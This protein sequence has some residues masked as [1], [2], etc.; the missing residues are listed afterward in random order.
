MTHKQSTSNLT[1][2]EQQHSHG[3]VDPALL[4]S[5]QGLWAVKWSLIGL[6]ITAFL[7]LIV[8]IF[9]GSISLLADTLH[10]FGDAFT[11]VPL[12]AAFK[13]SRWKPT[14]QFTYGYGRVEDLAGWVVVL[15]MFVSAVSALALAIERFLHPQAIDHLG[16]VVVASLVGFAGNE[17]VAL[18]RLKV[19]K[20]IGSA[21]LI[22]DGHHA[23][24]DGWT[25]LAVLFS[26]L[27]VWLG[28]P[29]ADPLIGIL[30]ALVIFRAT[31]HSGKDILWRS[32][33]G[34]DPTMVNEVNRVVIAVPGVQAATEIRARWLGHKMHA[35]INIAVDTA[36][37]VAQG[38]RIM[39]EVHH[40]LL[41][42]I[43][44]L[45]SATIHVDP[46]EYAGEKHHRSAE[47]E[48]H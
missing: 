27:G 37:S 14:S 24:T 4:T 32:L 11:A 35:E 16:W 38:H 3:S 6:A 5:S 10:N 9:S 2:H 13:A 23:R 45:S 15:A 39:Q 33:D 42:E 26:A 46:L 8:V 22:A 41:H 19:G 17:A 21:A 29:L 40:Q 31:W 34:I 20:E 1:N 44:H 48:G 28:Y 47:H 18:F 7:Q 36:L 30:I 12:W 25:S 43:Q